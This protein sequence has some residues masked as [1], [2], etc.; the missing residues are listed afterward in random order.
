MADLL[1]GLIPIRANRD[2]PRVAALGILSLA[3]PISHFFFV[4]A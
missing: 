1:V 2:D 4:I 3:I